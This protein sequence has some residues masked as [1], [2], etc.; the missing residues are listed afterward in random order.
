MRVGWRIPG[1][2]VCGSLLVDDGGWAGGCFGIGAWPVRGYTSAD[3]GGY[4][5]TIAGSKVHPDALLLGGEPCGENAR[6][7]DL[8]GVGSGA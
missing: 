5:Y 7:L 8:A 3:L 4:W 6:G 1:V 2:A